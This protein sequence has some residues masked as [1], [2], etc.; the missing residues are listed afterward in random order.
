MFTGGGET[1]MVADGDIRAAEH[2]FPGQ[3]W[4]LTAEHR[5]HAD[6]NVRHRTELSLT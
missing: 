6:V 5:G 4:K 1:C 3:V 2:D